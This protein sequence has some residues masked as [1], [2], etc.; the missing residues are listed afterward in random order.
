MLNHT[1]F[2][3]FDAKEAETLCRKLKVHKSMT[4]KELYNYVAA[5]LNG[6]NMAFRLWSFTDP[7]TH[8]SN[9]GAE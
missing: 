6:N 1:G 2:E 9:F 3:L 4:I 7:E 5:N 8:K